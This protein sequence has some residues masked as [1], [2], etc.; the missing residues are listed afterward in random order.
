MSNMTPSETSPRAVDFADV[1]FDAAHK[2]DFANR[3]HGHTWNVRG[4]WP[5]H[6]VKDAREVHSDLNAAVEPW[7]HSALD[8]QV[9]PTN[10]GVARAVLEKLPYLVAVKVWR[11]G[12]VPCGA[13]VER[14]V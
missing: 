3:I 5:A 2:G 9:E 1:V 14:R 8:G 11:G 13:Y 4:Y 12:K 7:D 6:P 10:A